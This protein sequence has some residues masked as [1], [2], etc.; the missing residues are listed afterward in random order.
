MVLHLNLFHV[1]LLT[2]KFKIMYQIT[3]LNR[4]STQ[5]NP[6]EPVVFICEA[7]QLREA[8]EKHLSDETTVVVNS[9]RRF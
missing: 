7:S 8:I 5:E 6:I 2:Y 9:L 3:V 4:K 1:N